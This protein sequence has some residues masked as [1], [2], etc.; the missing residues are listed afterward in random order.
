MLTITHPQQGL[1]IRQT[2][3]IT[4][5]EQTQTNPKMAISHPAVVTTQT[6]KIPQPVNPHKEQA[7]PK[8]PLEFLTLA[9]N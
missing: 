1:A 4:T 2:T 6:T 8:Q 7:V 5:N 3:R 9:S